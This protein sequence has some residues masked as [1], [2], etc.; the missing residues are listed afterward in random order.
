MYFFCSL[1][2]CRTSVL[3]PKYSLVHLVYFQKLVCHKK[4]GSQRAWS[5]CQREGTGTVF[6]IHQ[7]LCK[8]NIN[9]NSQ[10]VQMGFFSLNQLKVCL[11]PKDLD[12]RCV[13]SKIRRSGL[14]ASL[15]TSKIWIRSKSFCFILSKNFSHECL[16]FGGLVNSGCCQVDNQE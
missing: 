12:E 8:L 14:N 10:R 15:L 6:S 1:K 16:P 11:P 4:K 5:S 7:N 3:L 2:H 9:I 13:F